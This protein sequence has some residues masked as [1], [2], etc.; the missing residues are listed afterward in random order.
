MKENDE[1][2]A[3]SM[4]RRDL[5]AK[6]HGVKPMDEMTEPVGPLEASAP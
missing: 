3:H 5:N 6:V 1:F 4:S 2:I